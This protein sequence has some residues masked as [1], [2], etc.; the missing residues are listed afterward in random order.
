MKYLLLFAVL[1]VLWWSWK[2]RQGQASGENSRI[3]PEPENM[4]VCAHCGVHLPVSEC[5]QDGAQVYCSEA[6]RLAARAAER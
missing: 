1:G 6:H 5:L 4:V 3:E 2:K